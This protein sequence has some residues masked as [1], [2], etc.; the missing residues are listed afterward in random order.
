MNYQDYSVQQFI[1]DPYFREWVYRPNQTSNQF[2]Q[3][4]LT[5]HPEKQPEVV[6]ARSVLL[7]VQ[8]KEYSVSEEE[9]DQVWRQI[10][11]QRSVSL[12][13]TTQSISSPD[14]SL[15]KR[16]PWAVG[17][18][19]SLVL[20]MV[21][22]LGWERSTETIYTAEYGTARTI[23]LSDQSTVEL[24]A[25][26]SLRVSSHWDEQRE[27]WLEGEA[28]FDI[29]HQENRTGERIPFIVH[30]NELSVRVVGTEFNVLSRRGETQVGLHSG[31]VNLALDNEASTLAM[32]PGDW[33]AY[34]KEDQQLIQDQ[35]APA[36]YTAWRNQR[37]WFDNHRLSEI[38]TMIH[39]YYGL[40]VVLSSPELGQRTFSGQF[41]ADRLDLMLEAIQAT[42]AVQV[43]RTNQTIHIKEKE[44]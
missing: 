19:A 21:A 44:E 37:F 3:Q 41:P 29:Q 26:S 38:A 1:E 22:Y 23:L 8:F 24:N 40:E 36:S 30:T 16:W 13:P 25:N 27:V 39:D 43:D 14:S 5:Q 2:W 6:Q 33:V 7:S 15:T 4:W 20:L 17:I 10:R 18:A 42:L 11:Q 34:S 35:L 9:K 31:K 32:Q 28:F 12:P